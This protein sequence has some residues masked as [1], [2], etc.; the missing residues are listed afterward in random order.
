[1]G[2]VL[3]V[4]AGMVIFGAVINLLC[5]RQQRR[6][7]HRHVAGVSVPVGNQYQAPVVIGQQQQQQGYSGGSA[8]YPL[9][10]AQQYPGAP[11]SY[12]SVATNSPYPAGGSV[13]PE[14]PRQY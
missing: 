5:R 4:V 10:Q 8:P 14:P 13:M 1:M 9:Q 2:I 3:G 7:V 6:L 12:S 11:P